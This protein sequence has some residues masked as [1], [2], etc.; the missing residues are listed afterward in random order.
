MD[1][2][3]DGFSGVR[4]RDVYAVTSGGSS[5]CHLL[6]LPLRT[7]RQYSLPYPMFTNASNH[8][9]PTAAADAAETDSLAIRIARQQRSS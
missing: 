3:V 5:G 7:T 6:W 8:A 9:G 4:L 1:F 2:L